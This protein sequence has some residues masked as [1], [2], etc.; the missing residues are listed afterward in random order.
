M[1]RNAQIVDCRDAFRSTRVNAAV[2]VNNLLEAERRMWLVQVYSEDD[3]LVARWYIEDRT[4]REAY[5]E[6]E[7][8]INREYPGHDWTLTPSVY[9]QIKRR[10]H[11]ES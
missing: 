9:A 2:I 1:S 4:E 10:N 11:A 5:R 3:R 6:A 7:A 8:D